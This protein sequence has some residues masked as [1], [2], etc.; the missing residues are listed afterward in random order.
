MS[1][2]RC[3]GILSALLSLIAPA[4]LGQYIEELNIPIS[5]ARPHWLTRGNDGAI[6]FTMTGARSIGRVTPRG[7]MTAFG[8]HGTPMFIAAAG[9]GRIFFTIVNSPALGVIE[10]NGTQGRVLASSGSS[11]IQ[12]ITAAGSSVWATTSSGS[13]VELNSGAGVVQELMVPPNGGPPPSLSGVT[14]ASDGRVWFADRRTGAPRIG[15]LVFVAA[16]PVGP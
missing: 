12:G 3:A 2:F 11:S 1:S 13:V 6:W 9:D 14:T 7:E 4:L 16:P 8:T 5:D 10:P 15:R